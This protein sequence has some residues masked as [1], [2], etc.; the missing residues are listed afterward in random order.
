M[1]TGIRIYRVDPAGLRASLWDSAGN[2]LAR[3]HLAKDSGE[4][5]QDAAF[6]DPVTVVPGATYVASYFTPAT[7]YAFS[8][9]YFADQGRTVGPVTALPSTDADPNGVHCYDDAACRSSRC[10]AIRARP[11]G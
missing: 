8:Y 7:R 2:L 10:A 1:I 4:G 9:G 6:T 3:A 11:T 5:W